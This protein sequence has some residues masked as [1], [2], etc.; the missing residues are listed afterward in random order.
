MQFSLCFAHTDALFC[1]FTRFACLFRST[2]FFASFS[3]RVTLSSLW[4]N[5]MTINARDS[6]SA[7]VCKWRRLDARE[8]SRFT[9]IVSR[10]PFFLITKWGSNAREN[11]REKNSLAI[12]FC[13]MSWNSSTERKEK[14]VWIFSRSICNFFCLSYTNDFSIQFISELIK[15]CLFSLGSSSS[16]KQY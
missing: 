3:R 10:I 7:A 4:R 1:L 2:A 8:T 14:Y 5:D 16:L 11:S 15:P 9:L 6:F 13:G 12:G